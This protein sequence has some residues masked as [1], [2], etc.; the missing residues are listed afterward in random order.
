MVPMPRAPGGQH[1][2]TLGGWGFAIAKS[3]AHKDAAW[4]FLEFMA[5]PGPAEQ[6]YESA[7]VQSALKAFYEKSND[8]MQKAIYTVLQTTLPRP[9]VPQYAQA[10]DILQRY[11]SAALTNRMTPK[12]ALT[13]AATETRLLMGRHGMESA[14]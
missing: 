6:L 14:P 1:A 11:V 7:G 13:A 2:S 8:P 3:S 5:N 9:P 10:S 12:A 4:K